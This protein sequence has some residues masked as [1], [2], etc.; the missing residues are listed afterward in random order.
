MITEHNPV[1]QDEIA[2]QQYLSFN[3]TKLL[4]EKPIDKL[5]NVIY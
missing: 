2:Y 4:E 5:M 1:K 3:T